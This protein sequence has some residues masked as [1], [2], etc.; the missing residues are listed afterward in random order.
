MKRCLGVLIPAV[1]FMVSAGIAAWLIHAYLPWDRLIY[2][3]LP[4]RFTRSVALAL[5][6]CLLVA[7]VVVG[8]KALRD[9]DGRFNRELLALAFLPILPGGLA[10]YERVQASRYFLTQSSVITFA[11]RA[12]PLIEASL[13]AAMAFLVATLAMTLRVLGDRR[14]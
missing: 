14:G 3:V 11:D 8:I 4:H 2:L 5:M 1:G 9:R 6:L 7:V 10:V 12:P 13:A